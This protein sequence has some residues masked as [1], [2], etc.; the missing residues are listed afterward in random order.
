M[1][2]RIVYAA[3]KRSGISKGI[4]KRRWLFTVI[5]F[6]GFLL[7]VHYFWEEGASVLRSILFP[8][9]LTAL[10]A[11]ADVFSE[12]LREGTGISNALETFCA[13]LVEGG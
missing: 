7:G 8:V 9:D 12:E 6:F 3:E 2:Y 1:G 5:S 13:A 11:A 10:Q 4:P